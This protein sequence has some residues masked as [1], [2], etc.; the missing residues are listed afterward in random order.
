MGNF[1]AVDIETTGLHP[2]PGKS[3][4]FC[5]TRNDGKRMT[6]HE[7][8][9]DIKHELENPSIIKI[10]HNAKFDCL[11]LK[12]MHGIT[13]TN[14]W[15]TRVME[16][17]ILG[18][19]LPRREKNVEKLKELSS[20]L[21]WTLQ[22]Y[23][24]PVLE[25][26]EMA[27][28]FSERPI[29]KPLT[30]AERDY[31]INDVRHLPQLMVAQ[32]SRIQKLGL[33]KVA[34]L[35]NKLVE[36][37]VDMEDRGIGF[38][39]NIWLGI[40]R[41]YTQESKDLLKRLPSDVANWDSPSQ[42]KK[43]F[44]KQGVL[45]ESYNELEELGPRYNNP[46][47]NKFIEYRAYYKNLT[48]YGSSWLVDD[49]KGSTL[50]PD[51]RVRTRYEQVMN[52]GRLSSAHPNLQQIPA[53][54]LHR[55]AFIPKKG[56]AFIIADFSNQEIGIAA[57]ASK[58]KIWIDTLLRRDDIH[59]LTASIIYPERWAK[60]K[61]KKCAFPKKCKCPHH[62]AQRQD[63]KVFNFKILY[64]SG[65]KSIA[66]YLQIPYYDGVAVLSKFKRVVPSLTNWLNTNVKNS[67][68][69]RISYSADK[70][71]RRRTLRD[72]EDWMVRTVAMNN[73]IQSCGAN[74]IKLAMVSLP[75]GA[76]IVLSEHDSLVL[77]VPKKD[78][79]KWSKILKVTMEKA[80]DHCTDIVG[81]IEA[82]PREAY[83][84]LKD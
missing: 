44:A 64:G 26:K 42:V 16:Q 38:D 78:V 81:L 32:I 3:K 70:Y 13:V 77:E 54:T 17:V 63:G 2:I 58:E 76:P 43:Y 20:S 40:A 74:M 15:D 10:I 67:I 60:G 31:A 61:E 80:A 79:K 53:N 62:L 4:I 57:A 50:D 41:Q 23:G 35:E 73:P 8:I 48:T 18:E 55:T 6:L 19:N 75:K 83:N 59:S 1:I 5:I 68:K 29:D 30:Q 72:P 25:N 11:W 84:L 65:P 45:I 22:R 24:L 69:E 28:S 46:I 27:K 33:Q 66:E 12:R 51:G 82:K 21:L 39:K 37:L 52:T 56:H 7:N 34:A 36:V 14:I 47:L 49:E 9:K 71:R